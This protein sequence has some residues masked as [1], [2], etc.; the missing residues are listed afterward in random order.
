MLATTMNPKEKD[1]AP[2]SMNPKEK[3]DGSQR[4]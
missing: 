4:M 3:K 2:A 1:A